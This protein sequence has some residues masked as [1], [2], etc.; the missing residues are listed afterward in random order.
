IDPGYV[1]NPDGAEAQAQGNIVWGLSSA[2]IEE[3]TVTNGIIR[4]RNFDT[5]PLIT[6]DR[7]P[8]MQIHFVESD[9][10]P[11]GMGEPPIGPVAAAVANGVFNATGA[12]LR[13]LPMTPDRVLAAMA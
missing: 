6:L 3:M 2:L 7:M 9:G 13:Q 8:D 12:R 11:R 5:Y 4:P 10:V 1:V